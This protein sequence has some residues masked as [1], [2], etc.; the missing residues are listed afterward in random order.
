[1]TELKDDACFNLEMRTQIHRMVNRAIK[2]GK[3]VPPERCFACG[4]VPDRRPNAHHEDYEKPMDVTW[5]CANCHI[6]LHGR[7]RDNCPRDYPNYRL[8]YT[9]QHLKND[10]RLISHSAKCQRSWEC[11]SVISATWNMVGVFGLRPY[12][13][14]S[15]KPSSEKETAMKFQLVNTL[16]DRV[17]AYYS[18]RTEADAARVDL[19]M[20]RGV[21]CFVRVS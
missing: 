20:D 14:G 13:R 16:T 8:L 1:M 5:L 17:V 19:L 11:L 9:L 6:K 21:D 12:K 10:M 15:L 18:T 7:R 3:L 4:E 2:S